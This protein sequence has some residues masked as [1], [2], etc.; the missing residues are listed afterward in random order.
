MISRMLV[1]GMRAIESRGAST[2]QGI[3][4]FASLTDD[5]SAN[6]GQRISVNECVS[7]AWAVRLELFLRCLG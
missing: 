7:T 1:E 4:A 6:Q 5:K 3:A 2:I